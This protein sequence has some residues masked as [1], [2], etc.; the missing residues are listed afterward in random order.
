MLPSMTT[1]PAP[2]AFGSQLRSWRRMRGMSQLAL[3]VEAGTTPRH[4]SFLE[5]GRSRPGSDIV[6]RLAD[7]L[8]MPLRER[9]HLLA[10]AGLPPAF[11]DPAID[12]PDLAPFRRVLDRMLAAH[13]PFPGFVFDLHGNIIAATPLGELLLT[14][15][16]E[17]NMVRL[18]FAPDG[19]W[20]EVVDNWDHVAAYALSCLQDDALRFPH[21]ER[22]RALTDMALGAATGSMISA[23]PIASPRLRVGTQRIDTISVISQFSSPRHAT[24]QE[25]RIELLYPADDLAERALRQLAHAVQDTGQRRFDGSPPATNR[26]SARERSG[27]IHAD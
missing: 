24:L 27:V 23:A 10:V 17:R 25:L 21:D 15:S 3:A 14:G 9:N 13:A 2:N 26:V 8:D 7:T 12:A 11:D 18:L 6:L 22:L 5:T 20:R 4:V 19:A 16:D 1:A